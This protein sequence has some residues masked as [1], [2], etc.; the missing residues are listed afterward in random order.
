MDVLFYLCKAVKKQMDFCE[1]EIKKEE[2]L[3]CDSS[4]D[5]VVLEF[6]FVGIMTFKE[7]EVTCC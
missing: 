5:V 3:I 4:H 1:V 7:V 2:P 6:F